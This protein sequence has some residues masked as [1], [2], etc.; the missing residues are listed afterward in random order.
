MDSIILLEDN[1]VFSK[2]SAVLKIVKQIPRLK[3]LY[4]LR[5]IPKGLRDL[6]YDLIAKYRYRVFGK[7]DYC[8]VV[9]KKI[10][11]RFL[12]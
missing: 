9:D 10:R 8:P 3:F 5:Y 2:S 12:D 4:F 11:H 1:K 7:M 6:I